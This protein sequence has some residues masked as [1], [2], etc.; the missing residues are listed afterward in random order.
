MIEQLAGFPGNVV[1]VLC[2][3]RVTK[4][5]YEAVVVPA[6]QNALS[7]HDKVRLYY[8]TDADFAGLEPGAMWEDF[9]VGVEHL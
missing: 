7:T 4:A 2:T 8:E 1:A 6:V 5:D 9:K 3:G